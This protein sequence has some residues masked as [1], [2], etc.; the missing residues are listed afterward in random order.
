MAALFFLKSFIDEALECE[1]I[2]CEL[3]FVLHYIPLKCFLSTYPMAV[4]FHY[5]HKSTCI[6]VSKNV[7]K[8]V[9]V[10]PSK[11]QALCYKLTC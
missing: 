9:D 11:N 7:Y 8:Q 10:L 4:V 1:A 3:V 2:A 5:F 6:I